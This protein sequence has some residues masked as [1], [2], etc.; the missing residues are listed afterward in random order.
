MAVSR[1]KHG[2]R[3]RV[4]TLTSNHVYC[5]LVKICTFTLHFC[6]GSLITHCVVTDY[7]AFS[8]TIFVIAQYLALL[9]GRILRWLFRLH[10]CYVSAAV[11]L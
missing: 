1:S 2:K 6:T 5:T 4:H 9:F 8:T 7:L 10:C 3:A 11:W